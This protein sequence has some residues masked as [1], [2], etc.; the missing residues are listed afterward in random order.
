MKRIVLIT[1]LITSIAYSSDPMVRNEYLDTS[2]GLWM[3]EGSCGY[4]ICKSSGLSYTLSFSIPIGLC[5][6][7][8]LYVDEY[9]NDLFG[10]MEEPDE[11]QFDPA[12]ICFSAIGTMIGFIVKEL[13]DSRM[14]I[15][16]HK[17]YVKLSYRF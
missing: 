2:V 17:G 4:I 1:L 7:K 13:W 15:G 6:L 10:D 9:N 5:L 3:I 8:E 11:I 12:D 14:D 16:I